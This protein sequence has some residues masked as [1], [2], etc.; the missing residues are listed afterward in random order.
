MCKLCR[1][2]SGLLLMMLMGCSGDPTESGIGSGKAQY[3][4]RPIPPEVSGDPASA[5]QQQRRRRR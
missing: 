5:L 4:N 2:L 1:V 3:Q